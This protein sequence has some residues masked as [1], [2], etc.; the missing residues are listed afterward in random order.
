MIETMRR[1]EGPGGV[2]RVRVPLPLVV[3]PRPNTTRQC[4]AALVDRNRLTSCE[5]PLP[6][7]LIATNREADLRIPLSSWPSALGVL[8]GQLQR[9]DYRLRRDKPR[10]RRLDVALLVNGRTAWQQRWSLADRRRMQ[11]LAIAPPRAG[12]RRGDRIE[13]RLRVLELYAGS[14][15]S[16]VAVISEIVAYGP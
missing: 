15:A 2:K 11:L 4:L 14:S 10:V 9:S 5:L 12:I 3:Q 8:G 6:A 1:S 7:D 13:L 16:K